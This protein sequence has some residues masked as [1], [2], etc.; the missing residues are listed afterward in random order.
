MGPPTELDDDDEARSLAAERIAERDWYGAY[1]QAK[2]W[3]G[4]AGAGLLDPWLVYVVS[5][6]LHGQPRNAT[7][8]LDLALGGWFEDPADRAVLHFVRSRVIW[9]RLNDPKVALADLQLARPSAP[10]WLTGLVAADEDPQR[11]AASASRKRKASVGPAPAFA[12]VSD[13]IEHLGDRREPPAAKPA[14]WDLAF[15][16]LGPAP[17]C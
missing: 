17:S 2:G 13:R 8:S 3:I 14:L 10:T 5:A 15:P 11:A 7:H 6:L 1:L 16:E 4:R 12:G 9:H